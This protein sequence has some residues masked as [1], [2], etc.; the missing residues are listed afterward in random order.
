VTQAA[1][2]AGAVESRPHALGNPGAKK[3]IQEVARLAAEG[4][5]DPIVKAWLSHCLFDAGKP[6]APLEIAKAIGTELRKRTVYFPDPVHV[7]SMQSAAITLAGIIK[8]GDC[9]IEGAL[10]LGE[11]REHIPVEEVV[12]GLKIWGLDR[13]STV[14]AV[15]YKGELLVDLILLG[16]GAEV[17]LTGDHHVYVLDCAEHPMLGE[18]RIDPKARDA[19]DPNVGGGCR[20]PHP[21]RIE[22]RTRVS[23]LRAGMMMPAPPRVWG[24]AEGDTSSMRRVRR[25][26]RNVL[27]V[28]CWDIQTDDHRVYLAEHDVTVSN[29]DDLSV[30]YLALCLCA[31][32]RCAAVGHGYDKA[33]IIQHVLAAVHIGNRPQDWYYF[34][35]SY[36]TPFG[37]WTKAPTWEYIISLPDQKILCDAEK[38]LTRAVPPMPTLITT[39][40]EFIGVSGVPRDDSFQPVSPTPS[41]YHGAPHAMISQPF[42]SFHAPPFGVAAITDPVER[43]NAAW[44]TQLKNEAAGLVASLA[45]AKEAYRAM[46][47]GM[48]DLG[49]SYL[50]GQDFSWKALG[51]SLGDDQRL[52]NLFELADFAVKVVTEAANGARK[53][54]IDPSRQDYAIESLPTDP[55]VVST[56]ANGVPFLAPKNTPDVPVVGPPLGVGAFPVWGAVIL[57]V[58]I[59]GGYIWI[60]T[61]LLD[62][63]KTGINRYAQGKTSDTWA[64]CLQTHSAADCEKVLKS[65]TEHEK[66]ANP[67]PPPPFNPEPYGKLATS[68]ALAALGGLVVYGGFK[69][70]NAMPVGA[71]ATASTPSRISRARTAVTAHAARIRSAASRRLAATHHGVVHA[72]TG[73]GK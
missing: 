65:I 66:A 54:V 21:S 2:V 17:Y 23:E 5:K 24:I 30:A 25:V 19:T 15:E 64:A 9:F 13:W 1:W 58:A 72:A 20:C 37:Q 70:I 11:D 6:R 22:K 63:A 41:N 47:I 60:A 50:T 62:T 18:G 45:E 51:W 14:E 36:D 59:W 43:A 46:R 33:G 10:L 49:L 53:M 3:S 73:G 71:S 61:Q 29:C 32:I 55:Y 67:P 31:G 44:Q 40:G 69:A 8:G 26:E 42:A 27:E 16:N 48:V 57:G 38:C 12:V 34:D 68:L 4:R 56:D 28:P 52:S 39:P 35:P 7:E